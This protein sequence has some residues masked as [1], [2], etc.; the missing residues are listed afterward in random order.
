MVRPCIPQSEFMGR[1]GRFQDEMRLC[2]VDTLMV[3]GDEYRKENI[4][5]ACNYWPLFERGIAIFDEG[6]D[7]MLLAAPEGELTAHEMSVIKD[8]RVTKECAAVTVPEE[9]DYPLAQYTTLKKVA[10]ELR[11]KRLGLVG[12]DVIPVGL[13]RI[14]S[15]SFGVEIVDMNPSFQRLRL[16]K[17][18]N[19]IACLKEAARLADLA[20]KAL[21]EATEPGVTEL[22]IAG[23]A[24]GEARK[25]GAEAIIFSVVASG[26]RTNT[27]IPR[28]TSKVIED[29]DM[30]MASL[31]VQYEGYVATV[32]IPFA[33]GDASAATVK[34]IDTLMRAEA[35]AL[36]HLRAGERM[37]GFVL[38]VRDYFRERGLGKYD[39][40]PPLHGCGCSEAESPYPD[41]AT[42]AVFEAG[43]TV[44][45]DISLFG[46][47]GGSNR[48]EEGFVITEGGSEP[49]SPMVREYC[50]EWLASH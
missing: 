27:I 50:A 25:A 47:E 7:P 38:A 36:R 5:Y 11:T 12:I 16:R 45:T 19:E 15:E 2:G 9:I 13:H 40:Y 43:M 3:I 46:M 39:V 6:H 1:F 22:H 8:I 14:I 44:N 26:A 18:A 21:R 34:V 37:N 42:E 31:A 49:M 4:R 17:S 28:P 33:V 32:E 20:F 29:G 41:D 10:A 23:V 30:V 24:E 35:G 48:I